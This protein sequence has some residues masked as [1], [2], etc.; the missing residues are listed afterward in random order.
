[1][2]LEEFLVAEGMIRPVDLARA[3]ERTELRGGRITDNL[4]AL[5]LVTPEQ[6][7]NALHMMPP[8][9]PSSVESTGVTRSTLHALLL[10]AL[11][12]GGVD[13]LPGLGETL[14]LP[15]HVVGTLIEE[16]IEHKLL[17]VTGAT[18]RG[19]LPVLTYSLTPS[20]RLSAIEALERNQYIGP[21]PVT[22][23]AY[24]ERA[25]RQ[26]LSHARDEAT[27]IKDALGDLVLPENI[28]DQVGP[29]IKAGRSILFY[30]PPGNGKSSIAKRI[31]R[32]FSDV[33]HVPYCIEVEGQIIKIFDPKVHEEVARS[34]QVALQSV[35]LRHENFDRRW[36]ACRRPVVITGGE[37]S[38]DMLE[39]R[40]IEGSNF[41]EAPLHIK[42]IGGTFV[43]DDFGRQIVQPK[44]LLNRWMIPLEESVDYL[45]LH[46]GAT[47]P[48]PFDALV[49]FCTN[50]TPSDLMDAAFLRRIPYK[51]KLGS[52]SIEQFGAILRQEASD[53][54]LD[55]TPALFDWLVA[56]LRSR[57]HFELACYQPRFIV[58]HVIETCAFRK[59]TPEISEALV[60]RALDNLYPQD[61]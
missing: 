10:K 4:L 46:T 31:G 24:T 28:L 48:V 61:I 15:S 23:S 60:T 18:A 2:R 49:L 34:S 36:V 38:L 7:D 6:I 43:I 29:A 44:D 33:I 16:A 47:F 54:G 27:Q 40:Y 32:V 9:L 17:K 37:F 25:A 50:L 3:A 21:A 30:G 39:L 56:D 53:R 59:H 14:K 26:R 45:K 58:D 12:R 51:I 35:K 42:A 19:T 41:Y 5:K 20:G 22:L 55:F 1:M 52:P 13:S 57:R 11:Y 8:A